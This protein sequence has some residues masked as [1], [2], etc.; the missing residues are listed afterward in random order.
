MEAA[1]TVVRLYIPEATHSARRAQ[2][3]KILNLLRDRTH[4]HGVMVVPCIRGAA[5][6]HDLHYEKVGDILRRN[7]DPPLIVE[8]FDEAAHAIEVRQLLRNLVPDGHTVHW[9]ASWEKA[10][11]ITAGEAAPA[12][13]RA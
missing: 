2:L 13:A 10:T 6:T 5:E 8:F 4:V 11:P 12:K 7:P 1:V 9:D 3:Q